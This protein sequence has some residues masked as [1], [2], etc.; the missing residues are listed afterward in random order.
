ML[1]VDWIFAV[2][3]S[4]KPPKMCRT[5]LTQDFTVVVV[6]KAVLPPPPPFY[7]ACPYNEFIDPKGARYLIFVL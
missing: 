1:S 7:S 2:L 6:L 4:D 3:S 5:P